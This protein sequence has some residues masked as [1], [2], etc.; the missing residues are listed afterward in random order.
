MES[1]FDLE[2]GAAVHDVRGIAVLDDGD[3]VYAAP[4]DGT[5][6][7]F[8]N[9][10]QVTASDRSLCYPVSIPGSDAVV[11][12]HMPDD[13]LTDNDIARVSLADGLIETIFDGPLQCRFLRPN[14]A[15]PDRV[16]FIHSTAE[17]MSIRAIDAQSGAVTTLA[18]PANDEDW[19]SAFTWSPAGDQ[20][21]FQ[22][23]PPYGRNTLRL[24]NEDGTIEELLSFAEGSATLGGMEAGI[25]GLAPGKRL[26]STEG[27]LFAGGETDTANLGVVRSDGNYEWLVESEDELVP[28]EWIHTGSNTQ[29][30]YLE[31]QPGRSTLKTTG[32]T[33]FELNDAGGVIEMLRWPE[34]ADAPIYIRKDYKSAGDVWIGETKRTDVGTCE[35]A[36][37]KPTIIRYESFD[38]TAIP[39]LCYSPSDT[40]GDGPVPSG[41]RR[42]AIVYAHGGVG[43]RNEEHLSLGEQA[44]VDAGFTVLAP[45]YRGSSGYGRSFLHANDGKMGEVDLDDLVAGARYLRH[46]GFE[47]VGIFGESWGGYFALSGVARR[48][49]FDAAASIC[50]VTDLSRAAENGRLSVARQKFGVTV[51]GDEG[52][53]ILDKRSPIE[54]VDSLSAPVCLFHGAADGSVPVEHTTR[55]A[56]AL[57][58]TDLFHETRIYEGEGHL[59]QNAQNRVDLYTRLRSFFVER[60]GS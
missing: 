29:A 59:I 36:K 4:V 39:A 33:T 10:T 26:W 21:V 5:Y 25:F 60:L 49:A 1:D 18:E 51:D 30:A 3:P 48:S 50:G 14:P 15:N 2:Q 38:G 11:A 58:E 54:H 7:L 34:D 56:E 43:T 16:A 35:T 40:P 45:D 6:Q 27:I 22:D 53:G 17:G 28:V 37:C 8:R 41:K 20:L 52:S 44:L 46:Q 42:S 57:S 32:E 31:K 47:Q 12:M 9:G 19:L 13:G 55:F 24:L 23:G